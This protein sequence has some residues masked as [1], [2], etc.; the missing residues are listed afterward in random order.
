M[1][2]RTYVVLTIPKEHK[3]LAT[4]VI[5]QAGWDICNDETSCPETCAWGYDEVN[6]GEL[7]FLDQLQ[8]QGIA[9]VSSWSKGDEYGEGE[10]VLRFTDTGEFILK[11]RYESDALIH[12]SEIDRITMESYSTDEFARRVKSLAKQK[13][14]NFTDLPWDNQVEYG[15]LYRARRLIEGH[16][17]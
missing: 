5:Q 9:Y 15:K 1:G 14:E 16:N 10:A 8:N 2:D 4:K 13:K 11:E 6:Y 17:A 3:K 12:Y 7:P